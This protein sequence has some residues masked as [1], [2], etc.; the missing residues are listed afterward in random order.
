VNSSFS[1]EKSYRLLNKND[2]HELRNGSRFF[3]SD[4]LLFHVKENNRGHSRL[5][6]AVS[7]KYGNAVKRNSFK[8]IVRDSFRNSKLKEHGVDI[9]VLP[10]NK[11]INS[12]KLSYSHV[13]NSIVQSLENA[14]N[15]D[16][17]R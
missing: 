10:N 8:R 6:L 12:K 5:G 14:L 1:Y 17:K 2:F 13:E 4:I 15:K 9:L 3:V 16:F 7:K 11:K